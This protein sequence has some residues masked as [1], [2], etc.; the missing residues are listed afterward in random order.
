MIENLE[1]K[2]SLITVKIHCELLIKHESIKQYDGFEMIFVA[3]AT[4]LSE[5]NTSRF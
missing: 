5:L 3:V 4:F 1:K 2:T